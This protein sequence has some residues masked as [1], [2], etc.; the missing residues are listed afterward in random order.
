MTS[1][2]QQIVQEVRATVQHVHL[3][4]PIATRLGHSG[5][6]PTAHGT[7]TD[8]TSQQAQQ[9]GVGAL[10]HLAGFERL[11]HLFTGSR[12]VGVPSPSG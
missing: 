4:E 2:F 5:A 10:Q 3:E 1:K 6:R 8:S 9:T 11:A 12:C 7:A